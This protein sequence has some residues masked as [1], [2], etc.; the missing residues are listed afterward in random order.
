MNL[1]PDTVTVPADPM[2]G[3]PLAKELQGLLA[4]RIC[5]L[6]IGNRH[7]RDDGVGSL[8]AERLGF[9]TR[10]KVLDGGAVPE[11]FLEKV[12]RLAPDTVVLIDA[13]DF[14]GASGELRLMAPERV[15][16]AGVSTHSV[17]LGMVARFLEARTGARIVLLAV[18]PADVGTG[19]GV[20]AP[21]RSALERLVRVVST[22]LTTVGRDQAE[23]EGAKG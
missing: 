9:Q 10:A 1:S 15:A 19:T 5:M 14:G 12:A 23:G 18:Q 20:S 17:S 11:N 3:D 4:G 22:V 16:S 8:A 7:R 21:V 2:R 13:V 6:G